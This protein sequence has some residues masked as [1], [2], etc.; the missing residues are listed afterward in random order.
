MVITTLFLED[1]LGYVCQAFDCLRS[2]DKRCLLTEADLQSWL[3]MLIFKKLEERDD[4]DQIGFHS[5][6][7][8]FK[9]PDD[10]NER[11]YPDLCIL[12]R[13]HYYLDPRH[14]SVCSKGYAIHGPSVQMELKLRR[15]G[16]VGYQFK[17][18]ICDLIKLAAW[19]DSWRCSN[20]GH[21]IK[22]GALGSVSFFPLFVVYSHPQIQ[23]EQ[24]WEKLLRIARVLSVSIIAGDSCRTYSWNAQ[25]V[26]H[27][28][29]GGCQEMGILPAE[30][31]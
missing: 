10:R 11:R 25:A 29:Q 22:D 16:G 19:R 15:A 9:A 21:R 18:W 30:S 27:G 1:L 4:F 31:I 26:T 28:S 8:F 12:D 3:F 13:K 6:P 23:F 17:D 2:K 5:Q 7:R 20:D 24:E 14:L